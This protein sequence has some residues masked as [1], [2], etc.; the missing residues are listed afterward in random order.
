M[1]Q[2]QEAQ[3]TL[4][5]DI[6]GFSKFGTDEAS[7]EVATTGLKSLFESVFDSVEDENFSEFRVDKRLVEDLIDELD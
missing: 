6:L 5:G 7:M 1:A 3:D 4:I 2:V